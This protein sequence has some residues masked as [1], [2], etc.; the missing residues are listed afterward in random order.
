MS[1]P[2]PGHHYD[3][4]LEHQLESLPDIVAKSLLDWRVATLDREK[5]EAL[6][7]ARF[8]GL[9]DDLKASDLKSMIN[10]DP[11]RYQAVLNE[12]KAESEY[13]RLYEKLLGAKKLA[14]LRTAF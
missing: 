7:Y 13:Q 9:N 2:Q 10:A 4:N 5:I 6:L 14:S 12:I 11:E 3:E 1:H 8:K